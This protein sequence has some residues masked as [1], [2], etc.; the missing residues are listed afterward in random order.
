MPGRI[1]AQLFTLVVD[2][3]ADVE[4]GVVTP[5]NLTL[6]EALAFT[7]TNPGPDV[8]MFAPALSQAVITLSGTELVIT[9]SVTINT[10]PLAGSVTIDAG[11]DSRIF[12]ITETAYNV[13]LA[14]LHLMNGRTFASGADGHGGGIRSLGFSNLVLFESSVGSNQA[15]GTGAVGGGIYAAGNVTLQQSTVTGNK[16]TLLG[17]GIYAIGIA[18]NQS[19]VQFNE[20]SG[21]GGGVASG[22]NVTVTQSTIHGNVAT[23]GGGGIHALGDVTLFDSTISDNHSAGG[24]GPGAG[25]IFTNG[26]VSITR[27]TITKNR[28]AQSS[29]TAGA[30][31]QL[32]P[33]GS[34]SFTIDGSIVAGNAAIIGGVEI[35]HDDDG[36]LAVNY[37]LIGTGVV[38]TSGGNNIVTDNPQLGPLTYNG[39]LTETHAPL[40]ESPV[41]N[42]GDPN[43]LVDPEEFDQRG[44]PFV[45]VAMGRIDI[46]AVE[47]QNLA[48]A[49][50]GDYNVNGVVDAADYLVWRKTLGSN[51]PNYAGTTGMGTVQSTR[52][53]TTSGGHTSARAC[54]WM[55]AREAAPVWRWER[56]VR[57]Q[58]VKTRLR[59]AVTLS[60]ARGRAR[61]RARVIRCKRWLREALTRTS[62]SALMQQR[63]SQAHAGLSSAAEGRLRLGHRQA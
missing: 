2:N 45:R 43:I 39:G 63:H 8:I 36:E 16:A 48:T 27:S 21:G 62:V 51:V 1:E 20:A 33:V 24:L 23:S 50:L 47:L 5:G 40:A 30:V 60:R 41:I 53:T 38:P 19:T 15:T 13:T 56:R 25:G 26:N 54:P 9:D 42:A 31:L 57:K 11:L 32:N 44:E 46:G 4:D 18:L 37:S 49:H 12:H 52:T 59:F 22:S 10:L 17:G 6:R 28:S 61:S 14:G 3:P 35:A 58:H 55:P 34:V 7:N 29:P